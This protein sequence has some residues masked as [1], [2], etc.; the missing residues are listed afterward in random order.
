LDDW[1]PI[2]G[3][4]IDG[5]P[6]VWP[7]RGDGSISTWQLNPATLLAL[8]TEGFV[9]VRPQSNGPGR[10]QYSISYVKNANRVKI[11]SGEIPNLGR[12]D[13]HGPYI[14]GD[15]KSDV[16]PKTV[17]KRA[18]HDAGKWG[19]RTLRELLGSVFF[20]YAKSPYAVLDTLRTLVRS[21]P[22]ALVLDFFA[23]SGT[24]LHS[25]AMLNAEDD[26]QRRCILVTNNQVDEPMA[27][28]LNSE[29]HFVGDK[30]FEDKGIC[31]AVTVPRVKAA[32]TGRRGTTPIEGEY[33]NGR[34]IAE[35]FEENAAFFDLE[36]ADPDCI[37]IGAG[38]GDVAPV[39]WLASGTIGQPNQLK[40][41]AHWLMPISSPFAVLLDEDHF[42]TFRTTLAKRPEITHVW[43]VT[44]SE[45]AYAR[46]RAQIAGRA[47]VGMLYRD[48]LRNFRVNVDGSGLG[49]S[50]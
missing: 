24:T 43:L 32:L 37:E 29:G 27:R 11:R 30:A 21:N 46:M 35:G 44:D 40:E 8:A 33:Q 17:W 36:Y 12:E 9:R 42:R 18:R 41:E 5:N 14:T 49:D 45:A 25:V 2:A 4:T 28:R 19:S 16:I 38:L 6:V 50:P 39:L 34:R 48:Y 23:G 26:G 3:E 15:V 7:Y 13:N 47:F 10:N 31:R 22:D 1:R 20:D